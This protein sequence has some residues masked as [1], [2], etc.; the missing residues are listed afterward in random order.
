M[1]LL[2]NSK[3]DP[4]VKNCLQFTLYSLLVVIVWVNMIL[5]FRKVMQNLDK[6]Y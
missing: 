1:R 5:F 2:N 6:S 3:T 4:I